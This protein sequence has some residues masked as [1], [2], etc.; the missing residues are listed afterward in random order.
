MEAKVYDVNGVEK[1]SVSLPEAV[2]GCEVNEAL[3]HTVVKA[4][5]ANQRQGTAKTKGRSEVSGGGRKPFRQKG[6]GQARAGSNT[7]PLWIRGGKAHGA[8]PRDYRQGLTKKMRR[9]ALVS[10]Y[11]A[12][13]SEENVAVLDGADFVEPKTSLFAGFLDK[14]GFSGKKVLVVI[15]DDS[16]NVYLSGRNVKGVTLRRYCD[17]CTYD[18]VHA[19][20]VLFVNEDLVNKVEGVVKGE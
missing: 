13:A 14:I 9:G 1:S 10:A 15:S 11:S 20:K 3:V 4:Y 12:R 16:R 18:V 17:V 7:S 6:T 2:F 8:Q 5:L 19:D